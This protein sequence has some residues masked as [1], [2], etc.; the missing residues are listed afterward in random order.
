[1]KR[2]RIFGRWLAL[3]AMGIFWAGCAGKPRLAP[4][5]VQE[6][7][8][9]QAEAR[10]YDFD[11]DGR[12]EYREVLGD[13]GQVRYHEFDRDGDGTYEQVVDRTKLDPQTTRHVFLL[14]DGV[15][16]SIIDQM[17]QQGH[18]RMFSRPGRMVSQF[19]SVTDPVFDEIFHSGIPYGYEAQFFDRQT[20]RK[21]GGVNFYLSGKNENWVEG[22]DYRLSPIEDAVMY[23]YPGGVF[24][25]ELEA[26]RKVYDR[27]KDE[28]HVVLYLLS[29]D[30]ICHMF[31]R[32]K[33]AE[34][35]AM[36][37]R[38]I[39]QMVYDAGGRIHLTMLADHGN[40]FAGCE[41]VAIDDA[42]KQAGLNLSSRLKRPGDVVAPKFGLINFGSVFC[43][44]ETERSRAVAAILA[45]EGVDAIAWRTADGVRVI[46]RQ[47]TAD[48]VRTGGDG[49]VLFRYEAVEGDPL[50]V[51]EAIGQMRARGEVDEQGFATDDAWFRA[52]RDLPMPVAVQRIYR[53]LTDNVMNPAD[54]VVSLADGY[55][56]GDQS[57][58][59][60]VELGG[61]HGGL[62]YESTVSFFM[63]T[64]FTA[65]DYIQPGEILPVINRHVPWTP[66]IPSVDYA[67][68]DQYRPQGTPAPAPVQLEASRDL[69]HKPQ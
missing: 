54:I 24:K 53:S 51:A 68:L 48:I 7:G 69:S 58:G 62:S 57:F 66:H 60:W 5:A 28:Q 9:A 67:W 17:W 4:V 11:G 55:Y 39:V 21:T 27:K 25:R 14:L 59:D 52:T 19:P 36:L 43:Y 29:T 13:S 1:M 56:Y 26:A 23:L 41:Y 64:A 63:S 65:P 61:T 50:G 40:N 15:P 42:M 20:G 2:M 35:L 49:E 47:G 10:L 30:G 8:D 3:A 22:M 31:T 44:S 34:Y 12:M 45:L 46:N 37:D 6:R 32:E 38:W 16:F 18:F 33:A